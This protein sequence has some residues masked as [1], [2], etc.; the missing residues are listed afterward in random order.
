MKLTETYTLADFQPRNTES[1][2]W[3]VID[4]CLTDSDV[5]AQAVGIVKPAFFNTPS[6]RDLWKTI[7]EE[8]NAGNPSPGYSAMFKQ[9]KDVATSYSAWKT[10]QMQIADRFGTTPEEALRHINILRTESARRRC[11]A[12]AL[13]FLELSNGSETEGELYAKA[14]DI[15]A[16]IEDDTLK[17]EYSIGEIFNEI[18][19]DV[20]Q[21]RKDYAAG[22]MPCV[23]TGF[24][25]L[26]SCLNGG[27]KRG[28]L[29][30][31]A[32]RP[33]VGKTAVALQMMQ[34]A[35]EFG[36]RSVFFSIEM[37]RDELGN[38]ILYS[39]D[40]VSVWEIFSG[41][42]DWNN[43]DQAAM[44]KGSLPITVNDRARDLS[45]IISRMTILH[46][47]GKCD[48]AIVDYLGLINP[49][50]RRIP[51]YQQIAEVT[52]TM[53]V[54]AKRLGIPI[55]LLCQLNRDAAKGSEEP[56]L[57]H[58]RD[59]GSIEQDAD[60]VLM[61]QTDAVTNGL[62]IFVRKN[63]H[64]ESNVKIILKTNQ[65]RSRYEDVTDIPSSIDDT[66]LNQ[67]AL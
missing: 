44:E 48:L 18:A 28:Q 26:D 34:N 17:T 61:L 41:Q 58:L 14:A 24:P 33:S 55:L 36:N 43:F 45:E 19:E 63:R 31:M 59:S 7:V 57:Y 64:G 53:K 27:F 52:G 23:A 2:E 16:G 3:Q 20:E 42:M 65:T 30:I 32:A 38:R 11:H 29:I 40:K 35:A 39:T 25:N 22:R 12:A 62:N 21:R 54:T 10:Q 46:R 8:F 47:Q 49:T 67:P 50:D 1:L 60:I 6:L 37:M 4:D 51:L 15:V 56:Q 5:I 66:N 9:P 13:K